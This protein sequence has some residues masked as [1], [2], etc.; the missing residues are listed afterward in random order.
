[1]LERRRVA[2]S[3]VSDKDRG[4]TSGGARRRPMSATL[5][6]KKPQEG[7]GTTHFS[8]QTRRVGGFPLRNWLARKGIVVDAAITKKQDKE[9]RI[10]FDLFDVDG[11]GEFLQIKLKALPQATYPPTAG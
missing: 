11:S 7:K 4:L 10:V 2:M 1:L 8:D 3:P 6:R 5:N 9:L